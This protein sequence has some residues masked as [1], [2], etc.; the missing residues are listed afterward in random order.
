MLLASSIYRVSTRSKCSAVQ[1]LCSATFKCNGLKSQPKMLTVEFLRLYNQPL[2]F[3]H[4]KDLCTRSAE[5]PFF[6]LYSQVT[7]HTGSGKLAFSFLVS[8]HRL[9][10]PYRLRRMHTRLSRIQTVQIL[11]AST[12]WVL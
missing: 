3:T 9:D 1:P 6:T 5:Q 10:S 8:L 2:S 4:L 7:S 12:L 11:R